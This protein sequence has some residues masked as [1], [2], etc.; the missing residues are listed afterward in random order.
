MILKKSFS[1]IYHF[2]ISIKLA[3]VIF[4]SLAVLTAIGTFIE[5]KYDQ[6]IANTL[7][8]DSL[9]MSG[10]MILLAIN[11]TMVLVDRWPWKKRH[12][13]FILAHFGILVLMM[14][15]FFTKHFGVDA[16]LQ[17]TEGETSS[18]ISLSDMEIKLYSSYDGEK[19]SL[20]Y[21]KPVDMFS[22]KPS[23]KKPF[24]I[25]SEGQTFLIDQYFP[26]SV[27]QEFLK[28]AQKGAYPALRFHL[29]GSNAN[30][31]EWIELDLSLKT[32]SQ[33]YGPARITLTTSLD[34]KSKNEKELI[35]YIKGERIFYS[36]GDKEKKSLKVGESFLTG[37][38]D[39]EFRLLEFYPKAKKE[40]IFTARDKSSDE[41]VKAIHVKYEGQSVW[42]GQNSYVRF[43]KED[44]VYALAYLNKTRNL[45]FELKLLDFRIDNYQGSEK[46]KSYESEVQLSNGERF[47]ISMNE[48]LKYKG[49]TFY[50]SSFVPPKESD[51][52]Y[53]SI[54]SVNRDPGRTLKYM[55][56]L[57]V[58][59][60]ILLLFYRRKFYKVK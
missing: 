19:F 36:L 40:F 30:V 58:V 43:F 3:V 17:F 11:L 27:G 12:L 52:S 28:P 20:L 57:F 7:V 53:R 2:L 56:S 8:Y 29:Y 25:I 10:I 33:T 34:Y 41:T 21:E 46:A 37:W 47:V 23:K 13:P 45:D 54:L 32:V 59:M 24:K 39:F 14:G 44:R 38:M 48:P 42:I 16:T 55:G 51:T 31:V 9:W 5:S 4:I 6:E 50:Q 35:L 15:F 60:G 18:L 26:F 49:W 22:I 1:F